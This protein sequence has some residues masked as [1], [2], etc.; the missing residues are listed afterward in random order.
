MRCSWN[1]RYHDMLAF[2]IYN[3]LYVTAQCTGH[4]FHGQQWVWHQWFTVLHHIW[5]ATSSWLEIHSIWKVCVRRSCLPFA[6]LILHLN[7]TV[8]PKFFFAMVTIWHFS[9]LDWFGPFFF[10]TFAFGW[11]Y[12]SNKRKIQQSV[13]LSF[14]LSCSFC[15]F[16]GF[17]VLSKHENLQNEN[18]IT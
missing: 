14:L 16:S 7:G 11:S 13:V 18:A 10:F 4:S 8:T 2:L 5:E 15:L 1:C 17:F 6:V 12:C 3:V 9:I